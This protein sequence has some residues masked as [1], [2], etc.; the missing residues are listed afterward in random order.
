M[1]LSSDFQTVRGCF[2]EV[3]CLFIV[4]LF[5]VFLPTFSGSRQATQAVGHSWSLNATRYFHVNNVAA[6]QRFT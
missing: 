1:I 3:A 5:G 4:L 2:H 6:V